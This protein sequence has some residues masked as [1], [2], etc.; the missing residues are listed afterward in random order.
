MSDLPDQ[1]VAIFGSVYDLGGCAEAHF[2]S[3]TDLELVKDAS[4]L[5]PRMSAHSLPTVC[6]NK[7]KELISEPV[8]TDEDEVRLFSGLHCHSSIVGLGSVSKVLG[9]CG[10]GPI[11]HRL[12]D[13]NSDEYT[14]W[15]SVRNHVYNV[16]RYINSIK[17]AAGDPSQVS[18]LSYDLHRL[19]LNNRGKDATS[20]YAAMYGDDEVALSCLDELFYVGVLHEGEANDM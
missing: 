8:C 16:T 12:Q 15:F 2:V 1:F 11:A 7:E 9:G 6:T 10:R 19:I 4:S 5:F 20:S 14:E 13:L 18:D 17:N 3:S